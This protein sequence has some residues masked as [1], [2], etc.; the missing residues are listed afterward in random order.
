MDEIIYARDFGASADCRTNN[1][2]AFEKAIAA[3]MSSGRPAEIMLDA[4]EYRFN[5]DMARSAAILIKNAKNL[6]ISGMKDETFFVIENPSIGTFLI[7]DSENIFIRNIIIDYDPLPF[8]QGT[9]VA[10][11]YN[12]STIDIDIDKGYTLPD[13]DFYKRAESRAGITAN[14]AGD[15]TMYGLYAIWSDEVSHVK[16]RIYRIKALY[17]EHFNECEFKTGDRFFYKSSRWTQAGVCAVR[18]ENVTIEDIT[19]HAGPSIATMWAMCDKVHIDKLT[20]SIKPGTDRLLANCADGIHAFG[21]RNGMIVEN[22]D[23]SGNGDDEINIHCRAGYVKEVFAPDKIQ[24]DSYGTS[25]YRAGDI[26]Q[27]F[28]IAEN[29]P[30]GQ[31]KIEFMNV[32]YLKSNVYTIT[33]DNPVEGIIASEDRNVSD[34]VFNLSA[35]GQGSVFRNNVFDIGAGRNILLQSHDVLIEGNSFKSQDGWSICIYHDSNFP[36]GPQGSDIT[37]KGNTFTGVGRAKL[38]SINIGV[39]GPKKGQKPFKN[40]RIENNIFINPRNTVISANGADGLFISGNKAII[41]NVAKMKG[42]PL[43]FLD[44][45]DNVNI[46]S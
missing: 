11:D 13:E 1:T 22:S 6:T 44:N 21:I 8:T 29:M 12:D 4:G 10:F 15:E 36:E 42:N 43:F 28:D 37:I 19:I 45:S 30:R 38:A 16:D 46:N 27:I 33:L 23:F 5:A 2:E 40:I 9:V 7:N 32:D 26:L 20:V 31:A 35:C 41:D 24:V 34:M 14:I 25:D 3:A 39:S 17:P 18:S